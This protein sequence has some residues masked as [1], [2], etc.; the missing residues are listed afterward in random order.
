MT[1]TKQVTERVAKF[2]RKDAMGAMVRKVKHQSCRSL[3]L[4]AFAVN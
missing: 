4:C 1:L 3:R 2:Y